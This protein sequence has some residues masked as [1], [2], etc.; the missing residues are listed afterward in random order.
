M[1]YVYSVDQPANWSD[2]SFLGYELFKH[3]VS[4]VLSVNQ[5]VTAWKW[6]FV[7]LFDSLFA[8]DVLNMLNHVVLAGNAELTVTLCPCFFFSWRHINIF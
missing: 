1:Y 3:L 5:Y 8:C 7:C 6:S 4:Q 2:Y